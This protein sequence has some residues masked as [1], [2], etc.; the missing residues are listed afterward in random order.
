M[1][2]GTSIVTVLATVL[3]AV[4]AAAA[5]PEETTVKN[6]K[7]A[8]GKVWIAG[9]PGFD[10]GVYSDS[11][12]G[13]QARIL[14][15]LGEPM[16]YEDLLC[17]SGFAFRVQ[18]HKGGCPSSA[19]PYCGYECV[20]NA[21]RALPWVVKVYGADKRKGNEAAFDAE[22]RAAV[23]ASIDRGIP[24]HYGC[25]EDGL[26]IGYGDDGKRWWCMHPYHQ[27]G[28]V[29]FWH[30]E[31]KGFAGG[32]WPWG[33]AVWQA[34]K[35]AADRVPEKELLRAALAQAVDMW[36][37]EKRGDYSCGD[38]AY[39]GWLEWLAAVEAGT[40]PKP[41]GGMHTN[42]WVFDVLCSS[43]RIAGAW[44][45]A[46]AA[47]YDGATKEQLLVAAGHY[48]AMAAELM[49]GLKC[50]WDLALPPGRVKDWTSALRQ[51][52]IKRLTAA[53]AHDRA[54]SA[55]L[56]LALPGLK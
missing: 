1:P 51:E 11:V 4:C 16:T 26:I 2:R 28:K 40:W 18:L 48:E 41:E 7:R 56:E 9:V 15:A 42:G 39:R 6:V 21:F 33:I 17:Y 38:A 46:K 30:D 45:K 43:R 27:N 12:H 50:P 14:Q 31:V 19:H 47:A 37:T 22:V 32:T 8:D 20:D 3:L 53:R 29:E 13:S 49:A 25:E 34:P 24:V 52:Q 44:L 35:P 5:D 10:S 36:R 23:K 54:A 55:A